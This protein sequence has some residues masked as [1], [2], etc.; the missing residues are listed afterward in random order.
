MS[1]EFSIALIRASSLRNRAVVTALV[2]GFHHALRG[3]PNR[4]TWRFIPAGDVLL[5]HNNGDPVYAEWDYA[6]VI[7]LRGEA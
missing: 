2:N 4:Y 1:A 6:E 5:Y 7:A 3:T